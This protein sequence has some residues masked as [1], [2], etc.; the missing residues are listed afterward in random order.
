MFAG[1]R[2]SVVFAIALVILFAAGG[3]TERESSTALKGKVLR[4]VLKDNVKTA[5]PVNMYDIVGGDVLYQMYETPYQYNYLGEKSEELIPLLADGMPTLS[6]DRLTYTLKIKKGVRYQDD[7]CFKTSQG[8]GRELVAADFIYAW[9]RH[10]NPKN[11]SQGFWVFDGKVVGMSEF[12]KKFG[13]KPDDEVMKEDIE[14]LKA[15]DDH[16]VQIK[17]VKPYPQLTNVMAMTF[18][19][20]VPPECVQH[21]GKDLT[22]HPIGTGPFRVKSYD[23]TYK[24]VLVK[25]ENY[26]GETFPTVDKIAKKYRA[27]S[28]QYAGKPLPLVD[29]IDFEVVKEEQPRWLG[30]MTG[31]YDQIQLPKDNFNSAVK[32]GNQVTDEMKAKGVQLSIEPALSFWYVSINMQDP[33]LG[34]NKYLRQAIA[35]ATDRETWL[36]LIKNGC[37][38]VQNQMSPP[39]VPDRCPENSYRW[40]F[41]LK[42]AKELMAKAGYPDGKGLPVFKWDTRNGEMS[43]R[44]IAEL[45]TKNYAQIGLK[46][47]VVQNTF[48]AYLDKAHKGNLQLSKGGWVMDYPD[49]ENNY[50]LL[51]G[52]NKSPG[53]N[54]ANYDNPE[55]NKLYEKVALM[56]SGPERRKLICEIEKIVQEEAPWAYGFYEN[57]YRLANKWVKNFHT[58]ELA[59]TKWKFVD[60]DDQ[61]RASYVANR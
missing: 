55:F 1:I 57:E 26:H 52:P 10:A 31:K 48:P 13:T 23:P 28:A 32:N 3:C 41:D 58:A 5:D 36:K 51:Y 61:A 24:I 2:S 50:Q 8:K 42:R 43:E 27:D 22:R 11:E 35:A 21:Y 38:E 60:V 53:P 33:I 46:V 7:E 56:P 49:A 40:N 20:P 17:L 39:S 45:V 30:F 44:Q 29:A 12:A 37:G 6:K 14:G 16:T 54:E 47:E 19:S 34:K 4:L 15:V 9:K 25:N 18:T 59:F